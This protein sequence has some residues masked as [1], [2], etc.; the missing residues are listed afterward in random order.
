MGNSFYGILTGLYHFY[1]DED[2]EAQRK[3]VRGKR[4]YID[5]R[6]KEHSFAERKLIEIIERCWIHDP[7]SRADIFSVVQFLR[8]AVVENAQL[9]GSAFEQ[10]MGHS[11]RKSIQMST[12]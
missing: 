6:W 3:L 9:E 10:D 7:E 4:P 12:Y 8:E 2:E 11:T 5:E 1:L